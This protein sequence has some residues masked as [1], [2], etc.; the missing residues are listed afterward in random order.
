MSADP[1]T[2]LFVLSDNDIEYKDDPAVTQAKA[3]LTGAER[4]QQE[5]AEQ[6]RLER[7]ERK[8]WAEAE[9]LMW[10]I[11]E[12]ERQRRELEEAEVER[13]MWEKE[14]LEE[15]KRAEQRHT[16]MLQGSE[17]AAEWRWWH[18]HLRLARVGHLLRNW[19]GP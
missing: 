2:S 13:L 3:N 15:E 5:K 14:K 8:V 18:R 16:A 7:E 11:E 10:D 12:A 4:I 1:N 6:R 9:R 19:R 17:R